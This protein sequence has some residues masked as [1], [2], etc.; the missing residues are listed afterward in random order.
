M[1]ETVIVVNY[2][3]YLCAHEQRQRQGGKKTAHAGKNNGRTT[4]ILKNGRKRSN[5]I[6]LS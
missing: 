4:Y 5:S 3:I 6:S 2:I 1:E